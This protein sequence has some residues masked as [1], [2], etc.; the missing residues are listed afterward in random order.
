MFATGLESAGSILLADEIF[1][2]VALGGVGII[3]SGFLGALFVGTFAN[4]DDLERD[5]AESNASEIE[6]NARLSELAQ[7]SRL[8]S[9]PL[10][11]KKEMDAQ[12]KDQE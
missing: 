6:K 4:L 2:Q 3:L 9:V 7:E 5:F 10:E 1:G 11:L 12:V 8:D